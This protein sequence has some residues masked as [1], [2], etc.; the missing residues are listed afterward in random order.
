MVS[1]AILGFGVVGGGVAEVLRKNR[2]EVTRAVGDEVCV[3]YILD[4]REFPDSP[5]GKLVV[6]DIARILEDPEVTVVAETMGGSHPAYEFSVACMKAGKSVV[7]SNKEVVANF[8]VELNETARDCGVHYLFEASVGGGIP[9]IRSFRTSLAADR[10]VAIDGIM[11]GTTNYILSRM[12]REG[13]SFE[14]ALSEAQRLGYAE[15]NPAADIDGI[16]AQRKIA[17]LTAL[18]TGLL[19]R[20]EQIHTESM[21]G[22]GTEDM[23]AAGRWGGAVRLL[24]SCRV[25]GDGRPTAWVCPC[26][27]P[28]EHP[29][30]GVENVYNAIS[31]RSDVTGDLM[32]YGQGAGRFPTAGA[33]VSDI[34][35]AA[36]GLAEREAPADWRAA[37]DRAGTFEDLEFAYYI[38]LSRD[39]A[40][41]VRAE[42]EETFGTLRRLSGAP[43]DTVEWITA[44]AP[45]RVAEEF[46]AALRAQG[47]L[48]SR[49][50]LLK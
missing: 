41:A 23:A 24:G 13:I 36:D 47:W 22:I 1:I 4:L 39:A 21:A 2:A 45:E 29:L 37:G 6:H 8:G 16:D 32:Y 11:N 20:P 30:S 3:R 7:T 17:I 9:L 49:I 44:P 15:R 43:E 12:R 25:D 14:E 19:L 5:W 27:V 48:R 42:A 31:V 28:A 35:A 40:D 38:R 46:F 33:V 10:I 26:F 34:V 18:A 50:R